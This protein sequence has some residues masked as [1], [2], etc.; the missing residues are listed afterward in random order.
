MSGGEDMSS[1]FGSL[2]PRMESLREALLNARPQVCVERA[3]ITT[4][5]K[6]K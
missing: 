3:M 2:T 4:E 5:E 6:E 1:Y